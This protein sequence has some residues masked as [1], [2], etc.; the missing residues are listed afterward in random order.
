[1]SPQPVV[2]C[3]DQPE[4]ETLPPR[5]GFAEADPASAVTI[6]STA[7]RAYLKM[8]QCV[9]VYV[10]DGDRVSVSLDPFGPKHP[11]IA[12]VWWVNSA[13]TALAIKEQCEA[14]ETGDVAAVAVGLH[15]ALTTNAQAIANAERAIA[16][17]NT[18]V[19]QAQQAGLMKMLNS[20]YREERGDK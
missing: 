8:F 1:M 6:P 11:R 18:L 16:R 7:V 5:K 10:S 3:V 15:I 13:A 9:A 14:D 19:A 20:R 2:A 12:A 17:M 4:T